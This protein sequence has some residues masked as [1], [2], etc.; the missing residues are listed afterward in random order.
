MIRFPTFTII[1]LAA[2]ASGFSL[3][4]PFRNSSPTVEAAATSLPQQTL[5][6]CRCSDLNDLL[7]RQG[8]LEG[9]HAQLLRELQMVRGLQQGRMQVTYDDSRDSHFLRSDIQRVIDELHDPA[10]KDRMK[11]M[12]L[13]LDCESS[14]QGYTNCLHEAAKAGEAVYQA[15]CESRKTASGETV[16]IVTGR[17]W[18]EQTSIIKLLTVTDDAYQAELKYINNEIDRPKPLCKTKGWTG[19]IIVTWIDKVSGSTPGSGATP[20]TRT[21]ENEDRRDITI[22]VFDGKAYGE[23]SAARIDSKTAK[24]RGDAQCGKSRTVPIV[25]DVSDKTEIQ[26]DFYHRAGFGVNIDS[27]GLLTINLSINGGYGVGTES[28]ADRGSGDCNNPPSPHPSWSKFLDNE[29]LPGLPA[30]SAHGKAD[31]QALVLD[32]ADVPPTLQMILG[33]HTRT[34]KVEWHL[35]RSK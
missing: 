9:V 31:P 21:F 7:N 2:A 5:G 23:V 8:E 19:K 22:H 33:A 32:G 3:K 26:G 29:T 20:I 34:V 4:T 25:V 11:N 17:N 6:T 15:F 30:M 13:P 1:L 12:S 24:G 10:I 18:Q 35:T 27:H 14:V 16:A 28:H